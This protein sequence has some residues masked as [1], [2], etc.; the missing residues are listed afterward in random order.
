[1]N[2]VEKYI[3]NIDI[4]SFRDLY[5]RYYEELCRFA[6]QLLNNSSLAEEVVDDEFL[7]LWTNRN[8]L[9]IKSIKTYLF[10]AVHNSCIDVLRSSK[11]RFSTVSS[12]VSLADSIHFIE[13]V[14]VDDEHPLGQ[15]L[16]KELEAEVRTSVGKLPDDCK[17]V[18]LMSRIDHMKYQEIAR[19]L[20][21][22]VNTVKYHMKH[23]LR[24]LYDDLSKYLYTILLLVTLCSSC[25]T[26]R[27]TERTVDS[28]VMVEQRGGATLGYSPQSGVRLLT[29][30]GY[31]FKDLNGN[32][33]LDVY[34]DW[35]R[36]CAERAADLAAR[37]S[38][39]EMAG[40]ML[41]S[42]HQAVPM[43][44]GSS[45]QKAYY[46]GKAY[47][48]SGAAPASL[49]DEQQRFLRDDHLRAVLM[50]KVESPFVAAQWNNN[51]QAFVEGLDHGIP[52]N[53]SSDPRHEKKAVAEFNAGAG[54]KISLWP[55]PLGM[56]ATFDPVLMRQY[57]DIVSREYRALGIATAL[58]P[59]ADIA[60]EP[61]WWRYNGTFGEDPTLVTDMVQAYCEGLQTSPKT[62]LTCGEQGWGRLS[63]N[64]MVKHW[65]GYGAGEGGRDSHFA[66]GKY[67]VFPGH[68]LAMHKRPFAEGAF[69]LQGGTKMASAV[70]PTYSI[71]WQQAPDEEN[72]GGGYSRWLIEDQLRHGQNY[73]GVVCT[74]WSITG[75]HT[76][77][78]YRGE[79]KPWGVEH[80]T[81][82]ERHYRILQAGVDQFGGNNEAAPVLEAY[83]LWAKDH[84]ER[85]ARERYE[86]SARRLLMNM[87]RVGLFENPYV[88]P[89]QTAS[90]V[91]NAEFT[92]RGYEAQLKSVVMVK[93]QS[94]ILPKASGLKVYVPR[95]HDAAVPSVWGGMSKEKNDYPIDL[96]IVREY[97]DVTDHPEEADFA[98]CL[99][100]EP[101]ISTGYEAGE[102]VPVSLQYND[103]TAK[104]ARRVSIAGGDPLESSANRS[105]R[106]KTVHTR[107][108]DHLTMVQQTKEA[109]GVKPVVVVVEVTKPVVLSEVEPLAD[110]ILISFGVQYRAMLD[111]ISGRVEPSG[112]LPMQFPA[113]MT[114]VE[115]QQEDTPHDMRC[116]TDSEGH[117]YDFAFGMNWKGVIRDKRYSRYVRKKE[118]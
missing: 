1:M 6:M 92:A 88:D 32:D 85:N 83:R 58:S 118:K 17:R 86:L 98:L 64:A 40:L 69:R 107:N 43:A 99:M 65:Y 53:I 114:T 51:M 54:G 39:E 24:L 9:E 31:A 102:Y 67:A 2:H 76:A 78:D 100:D 112:L 80:L 103:Y 61:R 4:E 57:G 13:R 77:M 74:D 36:P 60:T 22:S 97:Y 55:S 47:E 16:D 45:Y 84:G 19:V 113:D 82:A 28:F 30:G 105:Y 12:Q 26:R 87:F 23:A 91:G 66:S 42:D 81:V 108:H 46:G 106:G 49:T 79:G 14:F 18:F 29:D 5:S 20:G 41:Y 48:E 27:W 44:K 70:M 56:A 15:L 50:T 59:Q 93:N 111:I 89:Q 94:G 109:M 68:H 73:D 8:R 37:L 96:N 52:V 62:L 63:V 116:Y 75:N 38:V 72:V 101:S 7:Y 95:R 71:L 117:R 11:H 25:S 21:I 33:T 35:R 90:T 10:R 115:T 104:E 110:A 3:Y 34:E